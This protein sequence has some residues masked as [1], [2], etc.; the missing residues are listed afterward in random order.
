[1]IAI[2][3][4]G[5]SG[6]VLELAREA[7]ALGLA[8]LLFT[9]EHSAD[10]MKGLG[11]FDEVIGLPMQE[12]YDGRR[13]VEHFSEASRK[14]KIET[15]FSCY[16]PFGPAVCDILQTHYGAG[17]EA[18]HLKLCYIKSEVRKRLNA[19]GVDDLPFFVIRDTRD[20]ETLKGE[21]SISRDHRWILKPSFGTSSELV[22][23]PLNSYDD[24]Q[25]FYTSALRSGRHYIKEMRLGNV[26]WASVYLL[27]KYVDGEEY[28]V[29]GMCL[30]KEA[31]VAGAVQKQGLTIINGIRSE[32]VNFAPIKDGGRLGA[33]SDLARETVSALRISNTPFHIE[34]RWDKAANR[35]RVV[36]LN[37]RLP[38]GLL[39]NIHKD[40]H[41]VRLARLFLHARLGTRP[42]G[43]VPEP[44]DRFYG[45][46]PLPTTKAGIYGG[47]SIPKEFV[48]EASGYGD[49][50]IID[51]LAHG[52]VLDP[53]H[54]EV[55]FAHAYI[56]AETGDKFWK[57][58][59]LCDRISPIVD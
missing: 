26:N 18:E 14:N 40:R 55:Y 51:F 41:G 33:L 19:D 7:G 6:G 16:D 11:L 45:D 22:S 44:D 37:P 46:L 53:S 50:E 5:V 4:K 47:V 31:I 21:V 43:A 56:R 52:E 57:A 24:L 38:G 36:E 1:M 17:S 49:V 9:D 8:I 48:H 28:S 35:P 59:E 23:P 54:S 30:G 10:K 3:S 58:V 12:M 42:D 39:C 32:G 15:V 2:F 29:E 27:E 34:M 13:L 25:H 20:L